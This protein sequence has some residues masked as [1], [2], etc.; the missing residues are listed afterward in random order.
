MEE[1]YYYIYIYNFTMFLTWFLNRFI[2]IHWIIFLFD[3]LQYFLICHVAEQNILCGSDVSVSSFG[4]KCAVLP[5]SESKYYKSFYKYRYFLSYQ[6]RNFSWLYFN[7]QTYLLFFFIL[8]PG[9]HDSTIN[10]QT[11]YTATTQTDFVRIVA[12][13]W[14]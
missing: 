13:K 5:C 10:I 9:Q 14:F 11:V 7:K 1:Y 4:P 3:W 2:V 6:A 12:T 8:T